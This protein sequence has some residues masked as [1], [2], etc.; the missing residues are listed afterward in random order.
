V[1]LSTKSKIALAKIAHRIVT[2]ARQVIGLSNHVLVTRNGLRWDLNLNEAID[3]VIFLL[4]MFE[5]ETVQ[6][7]R[8]L[9]QPGDF[10]LD[11][12]A[13]IGA[14]TLH[15]ARCVG[16]QGL[17]VAFEPT[18]FA[19]QK[20]V[21]NINENP[22]LAS[23]VRAEQ[24]MLV[25]KPGEESVGLLYSSWPLA[26][27]TGLHSNHCG[28]LKSTSGTSARTLDEYLKHTGIEKISFIKLD[29]DGHE[30]NVLR[31]ALNTLTQHKPTIIMELAP[32][33][34]EETGHSLEELLSI[35]VSMDYVFC[36]LSNELLPKNPHAI[37][38]MI[39]LG[40]S[41]NILAKPCRGRPL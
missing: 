4:G 32:Y 13:N 12:G 18:W 39:P 27:Q 10:V 36:N 26:E 29:V 2:S 14:H 28:E 22:D 21:K 40:G 35:L 24:T 25:S 38:A 17:V 9:V 3:L 15:L 33:A 11:I 34:L 5:R 31:G 37:R 6:V 16:P 1:K 8:R 30:C 41:T 20:L 19:F 7:Y 23:R